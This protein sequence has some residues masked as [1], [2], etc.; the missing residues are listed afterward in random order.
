M[1]YKFVSAKG[2][3][4]KVVSLLLFIAVGSV[5]ETQGIAGVSHLLEHLIFKGSKK[6]PGKNEI[7]KTLDSI[8]AKYN[9]F[10]EKDY[11][12]YAIKVYNKHLEKSL[13]LLS[14]IAYNSVL[15]PKNFEAEKKIVTEELRNRLD[16]K[17]EYIIEKFEDSVFTGSL[18]NSIGGTKKT[19]A[20]LKFEN[21]LTHYKRYYTPENSV[22]VIAGDVPASRANSFVKK[23]FGKEVR[24]KFTPENYTVGIQKDKNVIT[25]GSRILI[26][27]AFHFSE[28]ENDIRVEVELLR[29]LLAGSP[30]SRL[31][32]L[33]REKLGLAYFLTSKVKFFKNAGYLVTLVST[34]PKHIPK[35]KKLVLDQIWKL[36]SRII[37]ISELNNAKKNLKGTAYVLSENSIKKGKFYGIQAVYGQKIKDLEYFMHKIDSVTP[38]RLQLTAK[39]IFS[40][41]P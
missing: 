30:S 4:G 34:N 37:S 33:I 32:L 21:V 36:V 7:P 22:L 3:K 19:I 12:V 17:N 31:S 41:N 29:I 11:T 28:N 1:Q 2:S 14:D 39:K 27:H 20:N 38:K 6:F 26:G 18:S 9:A 40:R 16:D 15:T 10:T 13:E 25:L 35:I 24:T 23:Y 5:N 8:G